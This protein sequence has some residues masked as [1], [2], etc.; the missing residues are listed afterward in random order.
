MS[1]TCLIKKTVITF[2]YYVLKCEKELSMCIER[3]AERAVPRT[4]LENMGTGN[5]ILSE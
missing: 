1:A 2:K 3:I 4:P 5:A